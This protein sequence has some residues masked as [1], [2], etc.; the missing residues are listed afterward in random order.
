[1][2]ARASIVKRCD[3]NTALAGIE[4]TCS[5]NLPVEAN[6]RRLRYANQRELESRSF[7]Q[8]EE[9]D[10]H[11]VF[12]E[13]AGGACNSRSCALPGN[14]ARQGAVRVRRQQRNHR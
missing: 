5:F 12:S 9:L 3:R 11:E 4:L 13:G 8:L 10:D 1:M 7:L 6:S 14:R 2:T